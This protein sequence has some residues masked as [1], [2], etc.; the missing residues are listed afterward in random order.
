VNVDICCEPI[1]MRCVDSYIEM[2]RNTTR[3]T[4]RSWGDIRRNR[5]SSVRRT[6]RCSTRCPCSSPAVGPVSWRGCF[7]PRSG[8][9]PSSAQTHVNIK[10]SIH[11]RD[12]PLS[13]CMRHKNTPL[14]TCMRIQHWVP[15]WRMRIHR[16]VPA[17]RSSSAAEKLAEQ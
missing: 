4:S 6:C 8:S 17:W 16:W 5:C 1:T 2:R 10:Y 15:V 13:T 12:T 14:S 11:I 9:S 7:P 3:T